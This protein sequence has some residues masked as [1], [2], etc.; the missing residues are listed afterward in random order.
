VLERLVRAQDI[1]ACDSVRWLIPHAL[2]WTNEEQAVAPLPE[3]DPVV[4]AVRGAMHGL[5]GVLYA[6]SAV[7]AVLAP[8]Y[9]RFIGCAVGE[10]NN[11]ADMR[12]VLY[13]D[14]LRLRRWLVTDCAPVCGHLLTVAALA[15]LLL[16]AVSNALAEGAS[17]QPHPVALSLAVHIYACVAV[18]TARKLGVALQADKR[19]AED[20][21]AL[22]VLVP[23]R[24]TDIAAV[25]MLVQWL[26][27][28]CAWLLPSLGALVVLPLYVGAYLCPLIQAG[29]L[30]LRASG[31]ILGHAFHLGSP[32]LLGVWAVCVWLLLRFLLPPTVRL[33]Q[34]C[35][36][37]A[38][39]WLR[40][41]APASRR[42]AHGRCC[43]ALATLVEL[44][45]LTVSSACLH[46]APVAVGR[47]V[48]A[49]LVA[50]LGPDAASTDNDALH[51]PLGVAVALLSSLLW[52]SL[53]PD[54][55][56]SELYEARSIAGILGAKKALCARI[57]YTCKFAALA[58]V[59]ATVTGTLAGLLRLRVA[60]ALRYQLVQDE[61]RVYSV[62]AVLLIGSL[63]LIT[64][65]L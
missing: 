27:W 52:R 3:Q 7:L 24:G 38:L 5:L 9:L 53:A 10:Y 57:P 12:C 4:E 31:R 25:P 56:L 50:L 13:T 1:A 18:V 49:G 55:W 41:E 37:W 19:A 48:T 21:H 43:T 11:M 40:M 6:C 17:H 23:Q 22:A 64:F 58:V 39:S 61:V 16:P 46:R 15:Q 63:S 8:F 26:W 44:L 59:W 35:V 51:F 60:S 14:L 2:H 54:T 32:H 36:T 28:S 20:R 45:V 30:Q 34:R 62:G 65:P 29:C 47:C 42:T 33:Q